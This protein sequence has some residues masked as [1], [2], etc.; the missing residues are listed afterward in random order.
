MDQELQKIK[1]SATQQFTNSLEACLTKLKQDIQEQQNKLSQEQMAFEEEKKI[2][3]STIKSKVSLDVGGRRYASS[4]ET[5]TKYPDSMLGAMF[6]GRHQLVPQEDGSYFIDRD[7]KYFGEILNFLRD[8]TIVVPRDPEKREKI[9][10]EA[11]YYLLS[12]L[13]ELLLQTSNEKPVQAKIEALTYQSWARTGYLFSVHAKK[14]VTLT[15][16]S[17][18][19]REPGTH[20]INLFWKQGMFSGFES[21]KASWNSLCN[22]KAINFARHTPTLCIDGL[23]ISILNNQ[24]VSFCVH[25]LDSGAG[26]IVSGGDHVHESS[27]ASDSLMVKSGPSVVGIFGGVESYQCGFLGVLNPKFQ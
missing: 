17:F 23:N 10:I 13:E 18:I 2:I 19:S 12:K 4:Q 25:N 9:L 11:R 21:S 14:D 5:L 20:K 8:G 27:V 16:L 26:G 3:K 6:S 24:C 7:G 15:S 1:Q 22:E